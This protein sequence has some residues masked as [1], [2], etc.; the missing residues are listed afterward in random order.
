M[1]VDT[2][3]KQFEKNFSKEVSK[4]LDF[5]HL[6]VKGENDDDDSHAKNFL[7]VV[8]ICPIFPM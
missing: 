5:G 2:R 6:R 8:S 1:A 4:K 7:E 3:A